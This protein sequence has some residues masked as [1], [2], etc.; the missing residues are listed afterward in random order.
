MSRRRGPLHQ[1]IE[2]ES[3]AIV[4]AFEAC[5]AALVEEGDIDIWVHVAPPPAIKAAH[6]IFVIF[7]LWYLLPMLTGSDLPGAVTVT[8]ALAWFTAAMVMHSVLAG[9]TVSGLWFLI[10]SGYH[11]RKARVQR[12]LAVA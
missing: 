1:R 6:L 12:A 8:L 5:G 7:W 2:G 3:P 11:L 4:A 9:F 10:F